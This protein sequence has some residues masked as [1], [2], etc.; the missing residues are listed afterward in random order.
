MIAVL[1]RSG[2]RKRPIARIAAVLAVLACVVGLSWPV[3]AAAGTV[4][5]SSTGG[6]Q[7]FVVPA[8]VSSVDVVAVGGSGAAASSTG[9]RG[10]T[11]TG[12]LSVTPA[13]VLYVEVG[14]DGSGTSGG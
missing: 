11:V 10:A 3:S 6:E 13:Q 14:G 12:T 2:N 5:F 8:G 4:S 7:T 9:G 1:S